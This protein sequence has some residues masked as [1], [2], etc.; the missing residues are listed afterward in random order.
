[1]G[2]FIQKDRRTKDRRARAPG[3]ARHAGEVNDDARE[4][5]GSPGQLG[6]GFRRALEEGDADAA[7]QAR[8]LSERSGRLVKVLQ[9]TWGPEQVKPIGSVGRG[10]HVAPVHDVDWMVVIDQ[11]RFENGT[12]ASAL[13]EIQSKLQGAYP[14]T[15]LRP[16][17]RSVGLLFQDFSIDVVPAVLRKA[18]Q[19]PGSRTSKARTWIYTNP[20][21][22]AELVTEKNGVTSGMAAGIVRAL[23][24]WN[25]NSGARL[26]SFHLEVMTLRGLGKTPDSL[27]HGV[28]EAFDRL[29]VAVTK[30]CGDPAESGTTLDGYLDKPARDKIAEACKAAAAEIGTAMT[31]DAGG[32]SGVAVDRVRKVLGTPF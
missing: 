29:T 18:G 24:V 14:G 32:K 17:N 11:A 23:K 30:S 3:T 8:R 16:Q 9:Q 22:H 26:K 2:G 21:K 6:A 1:M 7:G 28:R 5:E 15:A 19:V 13:G 12:V 27:A 4:E 31:E 25:G 20:P 10:T